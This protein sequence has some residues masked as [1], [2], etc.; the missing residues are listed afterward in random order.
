MLLLA[1][2][3]ALMVSSLIIYY[4]G[5]TQQQVARGAYSVL[6][7]DAMESL[8]TIVNNFGQ[9]FNSQMVAL[10]LTLDNQAMSVME[11]LNGPVP[12]R[13]PAILFPGQPIADGQQVFYV[14]PDVRLNQ[15]I[16]GDMARLADMAG[17]YEKLQTANASIITS[18]YTAL[19]NGTYCSFPGKGKTFPDG[20]IPTLRPWFEEAK[21]SQ[22]L[23]WLFMSDAITKKFIIT[24]VLPLW[25]G[26]GNF[27]GATALDAD[28]SVLL[29]MMQLP[30]SWSESAM[31]MLLHV[32][33]DVSGEENETV[34]LRREHGVFDPTPIPLG[35][36][37]ASCKKPK[38]SNDLKNSSGVLREISGF[39]RNDVG[40]VAEICYGGEKFICAVGRQG[41]NGIVPMVIIPQ[42]VITADAEESIG[43]IRKTTGYILEYSSAGMLPI[44]L[45]AV[46]LAWFISRRITSPIHKLVMASKKLAYGDFSA[47][48]DIRTKD[49]MSLLGDVFNQMG[50][51]L[52]DREQIK[53]S[54]LLASEVQHNLLPAESPDVPGFD[55]FGRSDY[56]DETG[57][58]Y[59]DF[60]PLNNGQLAV[61]VGDITGHGVGA[62]LLMATA[63]ALIRSH[64]FHHDCTLGKMMEDVNVH[65]VHDT[66][67]SRFMTLFFGVINPHSREI[68]WVSCGHDPA[69]LLRHASGR[70]EELQNDGLLLGIVEDTHYKEDG[71]VKLEEDDVLLIG[72]DGIWEAHNNAG[73]MFGKDRLHQIMRETASLS[74]REIHHTVV[75]AVKEF[76]GERPP[77][78]DI[79]LAVIKVK[80]STGE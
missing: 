8:R 20:F 52:Q 18:Q 14:A 35:K 11:R 21:K 24:G 6:S 9:Q 46:G 49:E 2:M 54:L 36:L 57:G 55:I 58:D 38:A 61:A 78:D 80:N 39:L 7:E 65:M 63:R 33:R 16:D 17:V 3:P 42:N 74:A 5:R 28:M 64:A 56:C 59:F 50:P 77:E 41:K 73:D 70:M 43:L 10:R 62:A 67:D 51:Q 27:V 76:C 47:R 69:M 48:V 45:L 15:E 32:T 72:T 19:T 71:P 66:G 53:H 60:I 40:G 25:D 1:T 44:M 12:A 23:R 34:V 79:T 68:R 13:H 30:E 75:R 37:F 31:V 4:L 22:E 29:D 26:N